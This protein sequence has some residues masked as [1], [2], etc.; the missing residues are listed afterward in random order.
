MRRTRAASAVALASSLAALAGCAP[1]TGIEAPLTP[2]STRV[3]E[4]AASAIVPLADGRVLVDDADGLWV[5]SGPGVPSARVGEPAELGDVIAWTAIDPGSPSS[6]TLIAGSDAVVLVRGSTLAAAP[7]AAALDEGETVVALAATPRAG[8][9][10]DLWVST[11]R[12]LRIFRDETLAS[13]TLDGTD[14]GGA[15]IAPAGAGA[16]WAVA[17]GALLRV[18]VDGAGAVSATSYAQP[19]DV[20]ALASDARGVPWV[21]AGGL[22]HALE[23]DG[24]L[25]RFELGDALVAVRASGV[26][27]DVWVEA[28]S[29]AWHAMGRVARPVRGMPEPSSP[30][31]GPD[32]DAFVRSADGVDRFRARH[33]VS[34]EGLAEGARIVERL[35]AHVAIAPGDG[36][37]PTPY[38]SVTARLDRAPIAV[39]G[40]TIA[41]D[42]AEIAVGDHRLDVSVTFDD[43]T[44]PVALARRFSIAPAVT[45]TE[46]VR[47]I[48]V[49]FCSDC[50]GP[51][52]PSPTRLDAREAWQTSFD[53][54]L[55]NV[56]TGRMPL[57]RPP[58]SEDAIALIRTWST[59]GFPE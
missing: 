39:D 19:I 46:H 55:D 8:R 18:A 49:A 15:A 13:I 3:Y 14:L 32:G 37:E 27:P 9:E 54:I 47:P 51:A 10:A 23:P 33:R 59:T 44:L 52:G 29:G 31:P 45:W 57:G 17:E 7:L 41:I 2:L 26:G 58:L 42:P 48:Y 5:L 40:A 12:G 36:G 20:T 25:L 35:E 4:G 6:A 22:L 34:L 56:T 50:H 24:T 1:G 11:S 53:R 21:I 43:G 16:I 38:A 30:L 28:E